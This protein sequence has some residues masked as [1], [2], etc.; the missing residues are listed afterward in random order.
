MPVAT[1]LPG[2]A[3]LLCVRAPGL[4]DADAA[5][6]QLRPHLRKLEL[7]PGQGPWIVGRAQQVDLFERLVPDSAQRGC[8]SRS[9]LQLT[10]EVDGTASD[11]NSPAH[12]HLRKLSQNAVLING[13]AV[14]LQEA[15]VFHG[16]EIGFC[17]HTTASILLVFRVVIGDASEA[18]SP[19]RPPPLSQEPPRSLSAQHAA[20]ALEKAPGACKMLEDQYSLVCTKVIGQDVQSLPAEARRISLPAKQ[21][22]T[23]GRQHQSG[24]FEGLLPEDY[25]CCVSRSHFVVSPAKGRDNPGT[26][27][28][29]NLSANPL[30]VSQQ[31]LLQKGGAEAKPGDSIDIVG[32]STDKNDDEI[33]VFVR[34]TLCA[35]GQQR[36]A[37]SACSPGT[38]LGRLGRPP[39]ERAAVAPWRLLCVLALG[40]DAVLM[41]LEERAIELQEGAET[42]LG[43]EHQ[44]GMFERL[45]GSK[46]GEKYL[47]CVSRSHVKLTPIAGSAGC[48]EVT[49]LSVN[50]IVVSNERLEQGGTSKMLPGGRLRFVAANVDDPGSSAVTFLSL[51]LERADGE[52]GDLARVGCAANEGVLPQMRACRKAKALC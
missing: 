16:D 51:A 3:A 39:A 14:L 41:P 10:L 28:I 9:H 52:G 44:L 30:V 32:H 46:A 22:I 38:S 7:G 4:D 5:Q 31:Q 27:E 29:T 37:E 42:R 19:P 23:V 26:F 25:L 40:Q 2:R 33:H 8:I 24:F 11:Q 15:T 35:P 36:W 1:Q 47:C 18:R 34:L 6:Y 20:A 12:L 50:P 48:F 21:Q 43:R 49:N 45:L 13:K 17:G